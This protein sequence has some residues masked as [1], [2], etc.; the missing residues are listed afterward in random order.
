MMLVKDEREEPKMIE[1]SG[2]RK[3]MPGEPEFNSKLPTE[4]QIEE[5]RRG[6]MII[7]LAIG[8]LV[9]LV[10]IICYLIFGKYL[11]F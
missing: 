8:G 11:A 4:E 7:G 9:V 2:E 5:G 10:G 1:E 6:S 3:R